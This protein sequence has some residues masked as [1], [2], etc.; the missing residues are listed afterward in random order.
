M[1]NFERPLDALNAAKGKRVIIDLKNKKQIIGTL[2]AFDIHPNIVLDNAEE[3]EEG[4]LK[5]KLGC[6]FLRGDAIV[7]VSMA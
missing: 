6:I 7:L 3:R 5:R 4:E 1:I 2:V